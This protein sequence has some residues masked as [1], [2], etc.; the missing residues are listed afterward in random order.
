M[1]SQ[2]LLMLQALYTCLMIYAPCISLSP[3]SELI[4]YE[5]GEVFLKKIFFLRPT[6]LY[7]QHHMQCAHSNCCID[8]PTYSLAEDEKQNSVFAILFLSYTQSYYVCPLSKLTLI[9]FLLMSY[10][11]VR[12]ARKA[13]EVEFLFVFVQLGIFWS[14]K[15]QTEDHTKHIFFL[16]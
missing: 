9:S 5:F 16:F 1:L 15:H 8:R 2:Q 11:K 13:V 3:S 4:P 7:G 14:E 10:S 6:S 12:R